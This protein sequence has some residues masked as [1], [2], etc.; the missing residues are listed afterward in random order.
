[1]FADG[2]RAVVAAEGF[3]SLSAVLV[4]VVRATFTPAV[5]A[6]Q[7]DGARAAAH[8]AAVPDT[9]HLLIFSGC[10]LAVSACENAVH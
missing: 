4:L 8:G 7:H 6:L 1:M 9:R 3:A 5:C 2:F 10:F